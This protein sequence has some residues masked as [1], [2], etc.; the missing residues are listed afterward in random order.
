[1]TIDLKQFWID[2]EIAHKDNCFND[3]AHQIALGIRMSDECVF[4]EL[5]IEGDP[6]GNNTPA[7]V[8]LDLNKRYNDKAEKLVGKRLLSEVYRDPD[9][10]FPYI[11]RIGEVFGG[12]YQYIAKGGE[13][14][15]SD[16]N[17]IDAL[18]KRL[19]IIEK[20]DIESF[21]F[22]QNWESEKRRI[23]ETHGKKP[24]IM[25]GIR[26]PVTLAT[27][28][29]G[30][31]N[32]IFLYYDAKDVFLRFS[33]IIGESVLKMAKIMDKEAGYDES[34][35]PSGFFF[36]DDDCCLLT[37]EMYEAF[38]YPIL[39]K[40]FDEYSPDINDERY[41]HSDSA[42]E[43]LLPILSRLNLTGCNFGPT[44][45]VDKIQK[46]M[47]RTRIDGCIA[48]FTFMNNDKEQI[49]K[50]V[51]RDFEMTRDSGIKGLNLTTAG[52]IND[53]SSLES[54]RFIMELIQNHCRY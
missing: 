5:G 31:E 51:M 13:W 9:A 4:S 28:I 34:T 30:V 50:E 17:T 47:Q 24:N 40:L 48:P 8:R 42:M 22:P 16:I 35:R 23:F 18:E 20:M 26:G 33:N 12:T 25:H 49:R 32:L 11:K 2:D 43:H 45:T 1:M 53:G 6:W 39:K 10:N 38:G 41:Q 19:D 54:L 3:D 27:S 29:Y 44:V 52:S 36:C 46:Y 15:T 37:A 14:L 21:M 7:D